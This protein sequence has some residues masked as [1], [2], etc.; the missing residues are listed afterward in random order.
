MFLFG[1]NSQI[2]TR[3]WWEN[4]WFQWKSMSPSLKWKHK[5]NAQHL[6]D[7]EETWVAKVNSIGTE[8]VMQICEN[9]AA[10]TN[11]HSLPLL[12]FSYHRHTYTHS[13]KHYDLWL[14]LSMH[15]L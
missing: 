2:S 1:K 8:F 11:L 9:E 12:H 7:G 4:S 5:S 14:G 3:W 6:E 15:W 13:K 10:L